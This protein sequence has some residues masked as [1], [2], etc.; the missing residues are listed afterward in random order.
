MVN[1]DRAVMVAAVVAG[2][3]MNFSHMLI[4]EI[5]ERAFKATTTLPFPCLIFYIC[6]DASVPVWHCDRLLQE[7]KTLDISLIR[8]EANIAAPRKDPYVEVP[9]L[10]DDL[11]AN[12]EQMHDDDTAPPT[13]IADA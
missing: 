9:P 1:W 6:R 13:T 12:V 11:V 10:G 4:A 3:E 5:H 2:L 7:T 8:D